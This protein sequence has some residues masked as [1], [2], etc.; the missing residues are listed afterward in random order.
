MITSAANI[1]EG[2]YVLLTKKDGLY[3][4]MSNEVAIPS[5]VAYEAK[6][7]AITIGD[8][9]EVTAADI[10]NKFKWVITQRGESTQWDIRSAV[11]MHHFLWMRDAG[12]GVAVGTQEE[13]KVV[14]ANFDPA[15]NFFDVDGAMQA[16][17]NRAANK[18]RYLFVNTNTDGVLVWLG[19]SGATD[20]IVLV[21]LSDSTEQIAAE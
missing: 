8:N 7:V 17:T 16:Q 15:W 14:N 5:P 19:H 3:Y 1:T 9:G 12:V 10:Q 4:A 13:V 2:T 20:A 18:D 21:K 6:D 11:N